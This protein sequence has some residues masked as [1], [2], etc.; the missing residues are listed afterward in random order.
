MGSL[1]GFA[2]QWRGC[3]GVARC[4]ISGAQEVRVTTANQYSASFAGNP[5]Y[6][7]SNASTPA[8]VL[9]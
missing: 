5:G 2:S 9:F 4:T 3:A 8:V 6:K 1:V 7:P